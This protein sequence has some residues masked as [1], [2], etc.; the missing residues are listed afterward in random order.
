MIYK[1]INSLNKK[2]NALLIL[3]Q[4]RSKP[5]DLGIKLLKRG[6]SLD[7]RRPAL[8]EKLPE[9]MN[10]HDLAVIFGGPMSVNNLNLDYIKYEIEWLNVALES[11]KPFLGICLGAQILI[12]NLGGIVKKNYENYSEIGFFDII[13]T[14][15]GI[16]LFNKQK[17][18]FYWHNEGFNLPSCCKLLASGQIFENQ[19]FQCNNTYGIQF[20]PEVN[21]QLHLSWIYYVLLSTPK[22]LQVR[23]TQNLIKQM[24][25]R[26][27]H[28]SNISLWLDHFLDNY[29]LKI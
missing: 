1:N 5:G 12:K 4:E 14:N 8:G 21:F 29:L 10:N 26:I 23:G 16:N 3:H 28:N 9:T 27:K 13:P 22:K 7:I 24:I 25:L 17:T 19:A 11:K 6:Y 18:F 20:H 15:A 2:K